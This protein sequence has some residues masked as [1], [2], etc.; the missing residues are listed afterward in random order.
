MSSSKGCEAVPED[1][2]DYPIAGT[3]TPGLHLTLGELVN[4]LSEERSVFPEPEPASKTE[5]KD[6][7]AVHLTRQQFVL[8]LQAGFKPTGIHSQTTIR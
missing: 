6:T 5:W 2:L 8:Y 1:V 3:L 4:G 7:F